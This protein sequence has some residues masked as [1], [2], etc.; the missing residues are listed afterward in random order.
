[1]DSDEQTAVLAKQ[2]RSK[3]RGVFTSV[4]EWVTAINEYV[5]HPILV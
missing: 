1:M 4:R 5:A 3:H 2:A